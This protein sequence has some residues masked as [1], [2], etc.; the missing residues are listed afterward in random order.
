M[1][2]IDISHKQSYI[3]K[4]VCCLLFDQTLKA[5]K[6]KIVEFANM[7]DSDEAAHICCCCVFV[8]HP[9]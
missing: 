6:T 1:Q 8:L 3:N 5:S 2:S 7:G 4:N 9:W